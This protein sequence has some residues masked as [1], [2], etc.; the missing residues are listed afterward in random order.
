M[1]NQNSILGACEKGDVEK[2]KFLLKK[3]ADIEARTSY[4]STPLIIAS[5]HGHI[6]VVKILLEKGADIEAKTYIESNTFTPLI[7]ACRKGRVEV[8]K[9]LVKEGANIEIRDNYGYEIDSLLKDI[10][11]RRRSI[12]PCKYR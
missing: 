6:K 1:N 2:V 3:G 12:K 9:I 8:I 5:Y 7:M 4:G 11:E 10:E